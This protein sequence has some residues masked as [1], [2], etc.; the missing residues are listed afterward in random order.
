MIQ[1]DW[2]QSE[3][4]R[5]CGPHQDHG[6]I[7]VGVVEDVARILPLSGGRVGRWGERMFNQRYAHIIYV[8]L[9]L[10]K[11]S[12]IMLHSCV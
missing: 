6:V 9:P 5:L 10:C 8:Y 3:Q 2:P 11:S 12:I 1:R 4:S 7:N